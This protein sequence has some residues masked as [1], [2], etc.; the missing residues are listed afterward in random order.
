MIHSIAL[1]LSSFCGCP[2]LP[3]EMVPPPLLLL[4]LFDGEDKLL[5]VIRG[6]PGGVFGG[7]IG[8]GRPD[9]F[10]NEVEVDDEGDEY[11]YINVEELDSELVVVVPL[12]SLVVVVV[13]RVLDDALGLPGG[14]RG[15]ALLS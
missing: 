6:E 10:V 13:D 15:S 3:A 4:L 9:V 2:S 5:F 7:V 12:A 1:M 8:G 11:V 14:G